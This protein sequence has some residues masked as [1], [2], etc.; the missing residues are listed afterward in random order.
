MVAKE[1]ATDKLTCVQEIQNATKNLIE[2]VHHAAE[3]GVAAHE[4]ERQIWDAVLGIGRLAFQQFLD[5]E[6]IGDMGPELSLPNGTVVKR[7]ED[8]IVRPY[9]SIFGPFQIER[10]AYSKG[11]KKKIEFVP[12]DTRLCLPESNFSYLLQ[13]WDQMVSTEEPYQKVSQFLERILGLRQ[14]V[15]SLERMSRNMT[16]DAEA[17]CW[18]REAPP[19]K[20]EGA[21]LV[22][23]ADG[24]G[25][26]IRRS[27]DVAVIE[28]HRRQRGPKPDRKKM[29]TIGSVYSVDHFDRT[30]DDVVRALFHQ[31]G[32]DPIDWDRPLPCHKHVYASLSYQDEDGDTIDATPDVFGWIADEVKARQKGPTKE[33]V[34]IMDGQESLWNTKDALQDGVEMT[35]VLD[36]LHVTPRLWE[37]AHVFH[38][39]DKKQLESFIRQRV[40]R[41][42]RGDVVSVIRGIRQMVTRHKLSHKKRQQVNRICGYFEKNASRMRYHVYL[43]RGYPI[44]SGVIEGACRHV[45]K[46]RMER[47][48]MSWTI[49]GAR[50]LLLLRAIYT[51]NQWEPFMKYRVERETKRLYPYSELVEQ[52]NWA[53]AV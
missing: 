8:S 18:S 16:D 3:Q 50:A 12:L 48:G 31:P 40:R 38:G 20:E 7:M 49:P 23:T 17:F 45:I 9:V 5:L 53:L 39:D 6:G 44:A 42:L 43:A 13:D 21:L 35:E 37:L 47:T 28:D 36:L 19:A 15:D 30:P 10:V 29:A 4:V 34:C 26:P 41:I 2:L 52:A 14:H 27:A 33:L 46:D 25:V 51:T 1:S 32:D 11:A 24:K 22:Q